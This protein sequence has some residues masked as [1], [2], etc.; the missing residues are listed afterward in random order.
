MRPRLFSIP[1]WWVM[2]AVALA[3]WVMGLVAAFSPRPNPEENLITACLCCYGIPVFLILGRRMPLEN[4]TYVARWG[5]LACLP[6]IILCGLLGLVAGG[7]VGLIKA[8]LVML[9][10]V[11]W[12]ILSVA[13]FSTTRPLQS[14]PERPSSIDHLLIDLPERGGERH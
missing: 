14:N 7:P 12:S 9:L 10:M 8:A 2:N 5:I 3:A 4:V 1:I 6:F 11:G 13:A